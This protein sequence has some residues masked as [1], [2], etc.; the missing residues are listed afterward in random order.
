MSNSD[1]PGSYWQDRDDVGDG[2]GWR[3]SQSG[4]SQDASPWDDSGAGFWR[5]D[6]R[7]AGRGSTAHERDNWRGPAGRRGDVDDSQSWFSHTA[8]DL[9]NRLGLRGSAV[10][11]DRAGRAGAQASGGQRADGFWD[12]GRGTSRST[13]SYRGARRAGGGAASGFGDYDRNAAASRTAL[14]ERPGSG[15]GGRGG[16][17]RRGLPASRGE[18]FRNWLLDG[19]WWRH[20]TL[21][22][23]IAVFFGGIAAFILLCFLGLVVLYETTS[24]PTA[25]TSLLKGQSSM[26]Y[27]P[28]GKLLG[29]FTNGGFT[30]TV[31]STQ[32]IPKVMDEAIVAAEDRHFYTEGGISLTGTVRAAIEDLFGHGNLQGASTITE[33]Y[34]K[35]YYESLSSV[36]GTQSVTYKID[37]II[38]AIKIAHEKSKSWILT[39]YLNTAPFGP[40]TYGVGAA[41]LQYFGVNLTKPGAHLTL[42]QAAM[43]AAMPNSPSGQSPYSDAGLAYSN[44]VSR[45]QYVL[46]YMAVDGAITPQQATGLCSNCSLAAAEK[47]FA[48]TVKV[49]PPGSNSGWNGNDGYLMQMVEQ[50]ME[51]PKAYG[52]Y[53]LSYHRL[54]TG[55][56]RI[57]TTFSMSK[58]NALAH[59]ISVEES[60]VQALGG[61]LPRYDWIGAVLEDAKTGAIVAVY[62]GP[63]YGAKNC[64][65][66]DVDCQWNRAETPEEVGSSFKPYVLSTAVHEGMNV[67]TSKL[68]GYSPIAIPYCPEGECTTPAELSANESLL[69]LT[70]AP[71]GD[72]QYFQPAMDQQA[73]IYNGTYYIA[74]DEGGEDTGPLA[75]NAATAISSDP[76]YEDLA[77]RDGIDSIINM[78]KAFG[79]GQNPFNQD[80]PVG[81]SLSQ[82]AACSDMTADQSYHLG[83]EDLFST[84]PKLCH[85]GRANTYCGSPQITFGESPLTAVEQA[86][87]FATLADDG[88]YHSPHVIAKVEQGST[89]LPTD[90]KTRTVLSPAA[91]SDVDWALSFDNNMSGGTAD[92]T[93]TFRRGGIIG[94]TG[95]L[96]TGQNA[97]IAWFIGATPDQ[98][99]MSVALYTQ[100]ASGSENLDNLPTVSYTPGSQGGGWPATIWNNF[101]TTEFGNQAWQ[102]LSQV[103][104]TVNGYPFKAW[105]QAQAKKKKKSSNC[106]SVGHGQQ[107]C[108]NCQPFGQN[109]PNP[110]PTPSTC[111]QF[112]CIGSPTPAPQPTPTPCYIQPCSTPSP[113]VSTFTAAAIQPADRVTRLTVV[114]MR[115]PPHSVAVS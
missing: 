82:M 72:S 78:A 33:Q 76:A 99:A 58:I 110:N 53:G 29:T 31:L 5:S 51:A 40:T 12:A 70:A 61:S 56:Y 20:W 47:V 86:S 44:L 26:V 87:T 112:G 54:A 19:R 9:R 32:Q 74:F 98:Y 1:L 88:V 42:A 109:C 46:H 4:R 10:S 16:G 111:S 104:P 24:V 25:E 73:F 75:V 71:K 38:A 22:K 93:V 80:C 108:Q 3:R 113:G 14:R 52:G 81:G 35:N 59:S 114:G 2:P 55:G 36:A 11:R 83:M 84:N 27:L 85:A 23:A 48:K 100:S 65:S 57:Y 89:V 45:W 8:D 60:Q 106:K 90:V 62:G 69:S 101:M 102:P 28:N 17:G 39:Q 115:S 30:H 107:N 64:N 105:I 43:L 95:T 66:P 94:K 41:A 97:N 91:A 67:F 6:S 18:R 79:I 34:A 15:R 77:H 49:I 21:K 50:E 13:G 68:N 92:N 63:G 37:E 103:F 7:R 96:G